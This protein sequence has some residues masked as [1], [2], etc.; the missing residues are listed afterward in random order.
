MPLQKMRQTLAAADDNN[1]PPSA[2]SSSSGR[3]SPTRRPKPRHEALRG[4]HSPGATEHILQRR[5]S[6]IGHLPGK[7]SLRR[8]VPFQLWRKN[9]LTASDVGSEISL[10]PSSRGESPQ[11]G[12]P[13]SRSP[14]NRIDHSFSETT[15]ALSASTE[16]PPSTA[17]ETAPISSQRRQ[18]EGPY[19]GPSLCSSADADCGRLVLE[20]FCNSW[21]NV[22]RHLSR[23]LPASPTGCSET[24]PCPF[25]R[26]ASLHEV[27]TWDARQASLPGELPGS[28]PWGARPVELVR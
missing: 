13:R 8:P 22:P 21:T 15:V 18:R 27:P 14:H 12:S 17:G 23:L 26:R 5:S 11:G 3:S 1:M 28:R 4:S 24:G 9:R 16:C 25:R 20:P 2:R 6:P 7:S 19:R 10:P